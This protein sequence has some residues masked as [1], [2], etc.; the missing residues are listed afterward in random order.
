MLQFLANTGVVVILL[1]LPQ[2]HFPRTSLLFSNS[3]YSNMIHLCSSDFLLIITVNTHPH[4]LNN[5]NI[6]SDFTKSYSCFVLL[7]TTRLRPL[8]CFSFIY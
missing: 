8:A 1:L 7:I 6:H 4:T 3:K 2:S 5:R